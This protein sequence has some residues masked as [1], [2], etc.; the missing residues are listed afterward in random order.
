M[1]KKRLFLVFF[2]I[3]GCFSALEL[4]LFWLMSDYEA[5]R[6]A[7]EAQSTDSLYI[8]S[9]RPNICDRNGIPL[10]EGEASLFA[11]AVPSEIAGY[12][13]WDYMPLQ[14]RQRLFALAGEN[15]RLPEVFRL[16]SSLPGYVPA[17]EIEIKSRYDPENLLP[18]ILGY[19]GSDGHG[20]CGIEKAFDEYLTANTVDITADT[21]VDAVGKADL[22]AFEI[23]GVSQQNKG[24]TLTIDSRIQ[25][26][27]KKAAKSSFSRGAVLV[28]DAKTG[29]ILASVSLPDYSVNTIASD[30]SSDYSPFMNRAFSAYN[31]GSVFKPIVAAAAIEAGL[32]DFTYLCEGS[33]DVNGVIF[34][35]NDGTAHGEVGMAEAVASSCNCY[36]VALGR[37]VGADRL[38][39]M[40]DS[41]RVGKST[42]LAPNMATEKGNLPSLEELSSATEFANL[43]FGQG[44]L[45]VTPLQVAAYTAAIANGGVYNDLSLVLRVGD[46]SYNSPSSSV[47][48]SEGGAKVLTE[49]LTAAVSEGTGYMAALPFCEAAGKTGTAET[50]SG[51]IG[52]FSGFFPADDPQY[53]ITVMAEGAGY[54]F[55]SAAPVFSAVAEGIWELSDS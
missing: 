54:G 3:M 5:A 21:T 19:L 44:K 14:E 51:V 48:M 7:V 42:H 18:H 11:V 6:A 4:R 45:L 22:N 9:Q 25:R 31:A 16:K 52:W 24:I 35:C 55:S 47:I 27:A 46:E 13:L 38:Y 34:S 32:S 30:L 1:K 37:E 8:A 41:A 50:N 39:A 23:N 29:E 33:I 49:H 43:C 26:I 15:S 53:V 28:L 12:Q 20:V 36:F 2:F 10:T 40:A 17:K